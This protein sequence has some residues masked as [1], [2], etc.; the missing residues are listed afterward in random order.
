VEVRGSWSQTRWTKSTRPYLKNKVKTAR[1]MA[2]ECLNCKH[3]AKFKPHYNQKSKINIKKV[4][5]YK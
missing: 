3:N 1:E 5:K 2:Q 4:N